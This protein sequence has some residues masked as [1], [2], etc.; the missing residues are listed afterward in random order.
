MSREMSRR[1]FMALSAAAT[2]AGL[3]GKA[4]HAAQKPPVC[5]FS[6][7]LQFLDYKE[8]AKTCKDAGLDGIDLTVRGGGHVLPEN[9]ARDLP[10]A[11]EAIRA[12]GLDVPMITTR[13]ASGND[14]GAEPILST[15]SKLGIKYFR[16]GGQKYDE[17]GPIQPQLEK[18]AGELRTLAAVAEKHGMSAGYH[19]HSGWRRVGAPV[20]DLYTLFG[21]VGSEHIGANFDIGHATVEGA[22]GDWQITARLIAPHVK[23]MAVKDFVWED[24]D[25]GEPDWVPLGKGVVDTAGMLR[26]MRQAGFGGPISMHFEYH[27]RNGDAMIE[28]VVKANKILRKQMKMAGY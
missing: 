4:A 14:P 20:W 28:E 16:I 26:I 27:V 2:A 10:A 23:M 24:F 5:V 9:V 11:V 3:M 12:E 21:M 25:E 1:G 22:Y 19:N 6:K 18:F 15:A 13:L 17:A 7:H 8:L